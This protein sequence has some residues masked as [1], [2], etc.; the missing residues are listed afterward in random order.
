MFVAAVPVPGALVPN[1]PPLGSAPNGDVDAAGASLVLGWDPRPEKRPGP[2]PMMPPVGPPAL[3]LLGPLGPE[4]KMLAPLAAVVGFGK[5]KGD[6]LAPVPAGFGAF[7][8]A[9]PPPPNIPP[10]VPEK[11]PP[12]PGPGGPLLPADA[13]PAPAPPNAVLLVVFAPRLPKRPPPA[14]A[15]GAGFEGF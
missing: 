1:K 15:V 3:V 12:V 11:T 2:P 4:P 6:A 7:A 5:P 8:F 13:P 9:F 14:D 10:P